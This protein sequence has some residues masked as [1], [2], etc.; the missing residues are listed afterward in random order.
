MNAI[1]SSSDPQ[2]LFSRSSRSFQLQGERRHGAVEELILLGGLNL[3]TV[4]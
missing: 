2:L 1:A 4:C 3:N